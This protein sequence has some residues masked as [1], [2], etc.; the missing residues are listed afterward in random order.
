MPLCL[1][2]PRRYT[3]RTSC[4]CMR[5][6]LPA[7]S[8]GARR[9]KSREVTT[10]SRPRYVTSVGRTA[11]CYMP[12]ASRTV[13]AFS[14]RQSS[15][16]GYEPGHRTPHRHYWLGLSFPFISFFNDVGIRPVH[17]RWLQSEF[18]DSRRSSCRFPIKCHFPIPIP[19][20]GSKG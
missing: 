11:R 3:L 9:I 19:S 5:C 15:L 8:L 17:S 6:A 10:Q 7:E 16:V 12:C 2:N 4:H 18:L 20:N 14:P 1:H 13:Q